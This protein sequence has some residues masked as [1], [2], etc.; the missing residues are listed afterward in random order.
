MADILSGYRTYLLTKSAVTTI[1]S[2]IMMQ[3]LSQNTTL[4]AIVITLIAGDRW[5]HLTGASGV[6]DS[7][8]QVDC[9][10]T[11]P[12]LARTLADA[13]YGVTDYYAGA[14]G[15][16]DVQTA[17]VQSYMRTGFEAIGDGGQN[18][19]ALV[20]FDVNITYAITAPTT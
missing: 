9:Y 14:M 18:H 7:V 12:A 15:S 4:P 11:T 10:Q 16:V 13:V 5:G 8:V 20:G 2:T 17:L 1:T 3:N 6:A 19:R